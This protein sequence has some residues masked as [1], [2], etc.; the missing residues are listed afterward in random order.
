MQS[1]DIVADVLGTKPCPSKVYMVGGNKKRLRVNAGRDRDVEWPR[2]AAGWCWYCCHPFEGPPLPMPTK[3]DDRKDE[4]W[5]TGTFCSWACMKAFNLESK[6]YM[7]T[8]TA[9][10]ITLFRWRCTGQLSGI[11]AAP[12]RLALDVFGGHMSIR[13][14]REASAKATEF[15]V[16]PPRMIVHHHAMHEVDLS[17]TGRKPGRPAPD[18]GAVVSFKDVTT[19]NETL[20]LKRPM[21]LQNNR[22]LL[23]RTI[24]ISR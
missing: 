10:I 4:F 15:C 6:S 19:R 16:L 12:P 9:N 8:V 1:R 24:G 18:L 17:A 14:F 22:N 13:E 7:Q 23:E 5:V 2:E 3:Y 11:R 21:P 20:R